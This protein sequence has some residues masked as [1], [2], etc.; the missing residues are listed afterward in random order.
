MN[1]LLQQSRRSTKRLALSCAGIVLL[2]AAWG[3]IPPGVPSIEAPS[4]ELASHDEEQIKL[5]S[6]DVKAFDTP[7]WTSAAAPTPPAPPAPPPPPP[8]LKLQLIGT[9]K[10]DREYKQVLYDADT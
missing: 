4:V 8:P 3:L 10:E 1:D 5:P 6:L 9:L 7:A 2:G